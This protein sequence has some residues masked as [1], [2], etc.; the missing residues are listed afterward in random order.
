MV[1]QVVAYVETLLGGNVVPVANSI[2]KD[3]NSN[4]K[5]RKNIKTLVMCNLSHIYKVIVRAT[6][7]M[8]CTCH[9]EGLSKTPFVHQKSCNFFHHLKVCNDNLL[10]F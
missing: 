1:M 3:D 8:F 9:M 4:V 5:T 6:S 10:L 2:G 7:S